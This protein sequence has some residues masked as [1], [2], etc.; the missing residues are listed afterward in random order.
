M[1]RKPAAQPPMTP[2]NPLHHSEVPSKESTSTN[3]IKLA[4]TALS[5]TC[6]KKQSIFTRVAIKSSTS[7]DPSKQFL[8]TL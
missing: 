7:G 3:H 8:K 4:M 2:P 1:Q 5:I 6:L